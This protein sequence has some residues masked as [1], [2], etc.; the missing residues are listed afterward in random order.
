MQKPSCSESGSQGDAKIHWVS[1]PEA[2]VLEKAGFW[3]LSMGAAPSGAQSLL[4]TLYFGITPGEARVPHDMPGIENKSPVCKI[5]PYSNTLL[6]K[7]SMSYEVTHLS[8]FLLKCLFYKLLSPYKEF[9]Y[10]LGSLLP[11]IWGNSLRCRGSNLG[12]L[13]ARQTPSPLCY[14]YSPIT[15]SERVFIYVLT[16]FSLFL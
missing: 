3:L 11:E 9:C 16:H 6:P 7:Q 1:L 13:H 8:H 5:S 10:G 12:Q 14:R 4:L 15:E 2:V